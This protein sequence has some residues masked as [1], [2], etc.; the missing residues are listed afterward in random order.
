[1]RVIRKADYLWRLEGEEQQVMV[2]ILASTEHLT[3]GRIDLLPARKSDT[4]DHQGD[5]SVYVIDGT[6]HIY[7]PGNE[8]QR[9][10]ELKPGDGFYLPEGTPHQY[11]NI[12]DRTVEMFFA[13]SP[14]YKSRQ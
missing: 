13:V 2:G 7:L 3:V 12:T 8:D 1:M 11:H 5:E 6:L 4:H 9:W 14:S 10:F